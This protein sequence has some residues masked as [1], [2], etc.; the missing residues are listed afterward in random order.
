MDLMFPYSWKILLY[1]LS[2]TYCTEA[3]Y[4]KEMLGKLL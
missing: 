3:K 1:T 2:G 4:P